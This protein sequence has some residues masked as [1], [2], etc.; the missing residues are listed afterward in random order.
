[1][2]SFRLIKNLAGFTLR[3]S[4][5]LLLFRSLYLRH[6][7]TIIYY[8]DPSPQVFEKHMRY[9][10]KHYNIITLDFLVEAI[11]NCSWAKL[12]PKSLVITFDDGHKGNFNLLPV[13]KKYKIV[14]TIYV[15]SQIVETFRHFWFKVATGKKKLELLQCS[16]QM[17]LQHLAQ[18]YDFEPSKE[19][20]EQERQALSKEEIDL[21][22][23]YVDFQSHSRFHPVM[24]NCSQ[25]ECE[26]EIVLAKDE[27]ERL[28]GNRCK[29]FSYPRGAY[30][31]REIFYSKK[32][33]YASARTCDVGWNDAKTDPYR[34]KTTLIADDASVNW[35]AVQLTGIPQYL[36]ALRG[37]P[38]FSCRLPVQS[39]G[40][41]T[42]F[43]QS[44]AHK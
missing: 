34:L 23:G 26:Q 12:P 5:I 8:H 7:A 40:K 24:T 6:K 17:R 22:N 39:R 43:G 15:C 20:P 42:R 10:S 2:F 25:V 27:V 28:V 31:E 21:M 32:A 37:N 44:Q 41:G 38:N 4:G 16:N 33:V 36:H 14:P 29:H 9:L 18:E 30:S 19:Y 1:M 13:F 3:C 11:H 35:L